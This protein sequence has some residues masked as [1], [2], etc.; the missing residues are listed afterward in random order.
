MANEYITMIRRFFMSK[1][2]IYCMSNAKASIYFIYYKNLYEI[3]FYC[4]KK[5]YEFIRSIY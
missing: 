1:S 3:A 2:C 4:Y 5:L